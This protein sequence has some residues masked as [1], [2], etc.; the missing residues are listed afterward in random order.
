MSFVEINLSPSRRQLFQFGCAAAVVFPAVAWLWN[1]TP[2][3]I[4]VL[5]LVGAALAVCGY[6]APSLVKPFYLTLTLLTFPIGLVVS[7]LIMLAIYFGVFLPI[8]L[9]F[10]LM[11]RDALERKLDRDATSYWQ[12]KKPPR[13]LSSYF[14]QW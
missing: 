14:R 7:E 10:R 6:F 4:A 3:I 8:G 2:Q 13:D 12:R 5:A 9:V 1:A 11:R